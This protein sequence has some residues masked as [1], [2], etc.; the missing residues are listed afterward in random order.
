MRW[1]DVLSV[2]ILPMTDLEDR[3]LASFIINKIDDP[4]TPLPY[5]V[6]I[7]VRG[8]LSEPLSRGG[9]G[10]TL[11]SVNNALTIGLCV[12]CFKLLRSRTLDQQ[13]MTRHAVSGPG[14]TYRRKRFSRSF[15]SRMPPDLPH[16]RPAS[17]PGVRPCLLPVKTQGLTPRCRTP[18]KCDIG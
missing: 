17:I 1:L 6:A 7:S 9:S 12:D 14:R 2:Y 5:P 15:S 13:P 4:E 8:K 11:P 16:P 18:L 3:Y 10:K